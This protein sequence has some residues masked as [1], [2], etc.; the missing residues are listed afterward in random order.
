MIYHESYA[1]LTMILGQ[2]YYLRVYAIRCLRLL[3]GVSAACRLAYSLQHKTT[4][5]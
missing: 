2:L 3:A 5:R 4:H 1:K